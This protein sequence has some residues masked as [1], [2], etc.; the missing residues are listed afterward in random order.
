MVSSP[1][2]KYR[3]KYSQGVILRDH[4]LNL[5]NQ[6]LENLGEKQTL[7][8]IVE[9][10]LARKSV[11]RILDVGCGNA[12]ALRALKELF[13]EHIYTLGIDLLPPDDKQNVDEFLEGDIHDVPIPHA[14]DLVLSFR[15]LHEMGNL[16]KLVPKLAHSLAP[17]G[18]AYLWIRIR[19]A[20]EGTPQFVGE[21]NGNEERVLHALAANREINGCTMLL[22]PVEIPIPVTH[23]TQA[24]ESVI[25]GYVVLLH[26]SL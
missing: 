12:N 15:A 25:G 21:M 2:D 4:T 22:Q 3:E 10:I 24:R 8:H 17:G 19:D 23:E 20:H 16:L 13:G 9:R 7:E 6:F 1:A 11:C 26:R 18:R 5:Y 14:C